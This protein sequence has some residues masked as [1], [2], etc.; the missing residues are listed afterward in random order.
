MSLSR[1]RV[2]RSV[3]A[4]LRDTNERRDS[5]V[6]KSSRP[7]NPDQ[8][9]KMAQS[10]FEAA[11]AGA[12]LIPNEAG[13]D[14]AGWDFIVDWPT[15]ENAPTLDGRET[16]LACHVQVKSHWG[17]NRRLRLRLTSA[18]RLAKELKPAV[19][20][21]AEIAD[22]LTTRAV[23]VIHVR[24]EVLAHILK[25]LREVQKAGGRANQTF[26]EMPLEK[27]GERI[28]IGGAA[29]RAWVERVVGPSLAA[30][31]DAKRQEC[32]SIGFGEGRF[33]VT[34]RLF[35]RPEDLTD[36]FLGLKSVEGELTDHVEERFGISLPM[37]NA[38][39]L[40]GVIEF[41]PRPTDRCELRFRKSRGEAPFIFKA[42]VFSASPLVPGS[43]SK[44]LFKAQ[45]FTLTVEGVGAPGTTSD[46]TISWQVHTDKL[47]ETRLKLA[48]WKTFYEFYASILEVPLRL[49]IQKRGGR[50]PIT[51]TMS[52]N[53]VSDEERRRW[54]RFSSHLA[55]FETLLRLAGVPNTKLSLQEIE[56]AR[57]ESSVA[58]AA[59]EAPDNLG[60]LSFTGS[61]MDGLPNGFAGPMLYFRGFEVGKSALVYCCATDVIA[62]IR[63]EEVVWTAGPL[64][65]EGVVR[66][67]A[68]T[69]EDGESVSPAFDAF[70]TQMR[71]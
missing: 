26:I 40:K 28:D 20:Y 38:G 30:Y 10:Q 36:I 46:V 22:D 53:N 9:G 51:G 47:Q 5:R 57:P 55:G 32:G 54:R 62:D 18:E 4:T 7:L 8:L 19:I 70:I 2:D 25:R 24:G 68:L 37:P 27:W 44:L 29:F 17:G 1:Y 59:R 14:R 49:E 71:K 45:L 34:T 12:G 15:R 63:D 13:Y 16:P 3:G 64:R 33:K 50:A 61:L 56:D 6:P 52:A 11:C 41:T 31:V 58:I 23:R 21:A 65:F 39:P 35:A 43:G 42:D 67:D 60:A 48:D 69:L 66:V